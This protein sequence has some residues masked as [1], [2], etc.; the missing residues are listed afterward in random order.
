MGQHPG[1]THTQGHP[2]HSAPGFIANAIWSNVSSTSSC[3]CEGIATRYDK[4]P[5][6]FLAADQTRRR[7]HLDQSVMSLRPNTNSGISFLVHYLCLTAR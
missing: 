5:L 4:D 2:S 7:P 1:E 6:N 3:S